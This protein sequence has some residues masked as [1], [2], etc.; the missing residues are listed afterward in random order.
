MDKGKLGAFLLGLTVWVP[1]LILAYDLSPFKL[2]VTGDM[3]GWETKPPMFSPDYPITGTYTGIS[4][5]VLF[6]VAYGAI[7]FW[8]A[9]LM[10]TPHTEGFPS[11]HEVEETNE[12]ETTFWTWYPQFWKS[13][14]K[15]IVKCI[16]KPKISPSTEQDLGFWGTLLGCAVCYWFLGVLASV[17][18]FIGFHLVF[19]H[20]VYRKRQK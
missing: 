5:L 13:L 4:S 15:R 19:L 9:F 12:K 10:R 1:F 3:W 16:T 14:F 8:I 2:V 11:P 20:G 6:Y 7:V 18:W 17:F